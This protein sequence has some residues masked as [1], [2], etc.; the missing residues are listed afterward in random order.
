[1]TVCVWGGGGGAG[2]REGAGGGGAPGAEINN[3][4]YMSSDGDEC[5]TEA[6]TLRI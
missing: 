2:A 3:E 6:R 1:M 5:G 4:R